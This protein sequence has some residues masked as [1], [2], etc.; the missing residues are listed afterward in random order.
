MLKESGQLRV[1]A[2]LYETKGMI[3]LA[4]Q[5]WQALAEGSI[6]MQ[7]KRVLSGRRIQDDKSLN[8]V[9][10]Q[11]LQLTAAKEASR[12]LETS[13]DGDLVLAHLKWVRFVEVFCSIKCCQVLKH[14]NIAMDF[15]IQLRKCRS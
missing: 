15:F 9:D 5:V 7:G 8:Q 2:F 11:I 14:I 13:S 3:A 4:L 6:P 10:L 1:L 12:L